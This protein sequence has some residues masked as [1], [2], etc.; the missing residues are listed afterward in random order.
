MVLA[1]APETSD[2]SSLAISSNI[3]SLEICYNLPWLDQFD[4]YMPIFKKS[5]RINH[6]KKCKP[7]VF[8]R[9]NDRHVR[10]SLQ[11]SRYSEIDFLLSRC[12]NDVATIYRN[13]MPKDLQMG[14]T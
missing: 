8:D 6:E 4:F 11:F 12:Q 7:K 3:L 2:C 14:R 1:P 5:H 10:F 13:N 9:Y